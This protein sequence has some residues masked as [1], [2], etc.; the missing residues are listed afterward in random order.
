MPQTLTCVHTH[1]REQGPSLVTRLLLQVLTLSLKRAKTSLTT[2]ERDLERLVNEHSL[3]L[4]PFQTAATASKTMQQELEQKL[5]VRD[6][7]FEKLR[8]QLQVAP[9]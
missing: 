1:G 8:A 7:G 3:A 2:K 4:E 9:H 6:D 5:R